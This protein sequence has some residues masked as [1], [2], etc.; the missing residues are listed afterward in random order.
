M[1]LRFS[2]VFL[3]LLG[4]LAGIGLMPS[5]VLAQAETKGWYATIYAQQSRLGAS[6]LAESGAA[7][8]GSGLRAEFGS[9]TGFGG[10]IG[11]RCGN[12]WAAEVEWNYRSHSLDALRQ[13][14]TNRAREGDFASNIFLELIR[15]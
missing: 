14:S 13:G 2:K 10:D 5:A 11:W 1:S 15:K 8:A 6:G 9:G 12:G 3:R 4:S 7:G